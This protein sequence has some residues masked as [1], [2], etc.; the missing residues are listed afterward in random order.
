MKYIRL[1]RFVKK[2]PKHR[3]K[4]GK[5]KILSADKLRDWSLLV[6]GRDGYHCRSCSS[7]K[8]IHA[9]HIVSKYY[10]PQHAYKIDNGISLCKSCHLGTRGVHGKSKP[11]NKFIKLLRDI[12]YN[13]DIVKAMMLNK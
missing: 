9:H 6:R 13:N 8:K 7:K 2:K 3:R 1:K 5:K 11:K 4:R 12:Y 10:R